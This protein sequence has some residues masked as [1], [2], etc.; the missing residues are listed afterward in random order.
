M[1]HMRIA[2]E[3]DEAKIG[4][5]RI[6]TAKG[7]ELRVKHKHSSLYVN[8]DPVSNWKPIFLSPTCLVFGY[9]LKSASAKSAKV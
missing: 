2:D 6:K 9:Y 5:S 8:I 4:K 3:G 7:K 1:K